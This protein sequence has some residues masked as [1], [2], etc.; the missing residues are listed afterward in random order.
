MASI[1]RTDSLSDDVR[2][3]VAAPPGE[4]VRKEHSRRRAIAFGLLHG[5]TFPT[6]FVRTE[7]FGGVT[8]GRGQ[9]DAE[10][11]DPKGLAVYPA[12]PWLDSWLDRPELPVL[13]HGREMRVPLK[14]RYFS[15][16]A[17]LSAG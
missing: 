9:T 10:R 4:T 17:I 14:R 12:D 6:P 5:V 15:S 7:A 13:R 11:R 1:V 16:T 2:V 8:S 3:I